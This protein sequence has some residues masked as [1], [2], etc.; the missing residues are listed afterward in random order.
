MI[1]SGWRPRVK[2]E[3][4]LE[5]TVDNRIRI[6]GAVYGI[7]AEV[8]DR[9]GGVWTMLNAAD[10]TRSPDEIVQHV[11][12]VH[13]G[14]RGGAVYA[15]L[16]Q[17]ADAGY[18]EDAAAPDPPLL[19][20]REKE[21]YERSRQFYRWVDLNPRDSSW[22]PQVRL[23]RA[24]VVLVGLGGTGGAA[25]LALAASGVGRLHCVDSDAVQLSNLNRQTM[26]AEADVGRPKVEVAMERLRRLNSDID[27]TGECVN[28]RAESDLR[29]LVRNRDVFVLRADRPGEIRPGSTGS[30][31]PPAR[32]GPCYECA[33]L[34]EHEQHGVVYPD[35]RYSVERDSSNAVT[36]AS[37][38]LSG[39]LAAHLTTAL[40]AG[41]VPVEPG[42]T[43]G[44][45][46]AA[47]DHHILVTHRQHPR[48]PACGTT[49]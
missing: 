47:A 23:K 5:Q 29:P 25:A 45:N 11:L 37:A 6:G 30:V 28:V 22:D 4:G 18:L 20:V 15:A 38:G 42:Q 26:Y 34:T 24:R 21:R 36:A 10:G 49:P 41:V 12:S 14:E 7:A 1:R 3:H 33:W 8:V 44:I 46:L 31:S 39:L 27:V 17:V 35:R 16:D 40:I 2:P 48:C 43:M 9:T 19:T 32:R 13:P